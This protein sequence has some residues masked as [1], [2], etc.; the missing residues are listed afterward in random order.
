MMVFSFHH[1]WGQ[2]EEH[3]YSGLS[4]SSLQIS[5]FYHFRVYKPQ[6][7]HVYPEGPKQTDPGD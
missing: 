2:V 3:F 1:T 6:E 7:T 4:G 5:F